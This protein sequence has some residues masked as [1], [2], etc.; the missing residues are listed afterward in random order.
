M[1]DGDEILSG[2]FIAGFVAVGISCIGYYLK[3]RCVKRTMKSSTSQT[4]LTNL[5]DPEQI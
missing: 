4:N 1:A 3:N 5:G 2:F